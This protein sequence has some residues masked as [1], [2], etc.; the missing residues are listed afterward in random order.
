MEA[1]LSRLGATFCGTNDAQSSYSVFI[2]KMKVDGADQARIA[3]DEGE[4]VKAIY[5]MFEDT[6][7]PWKYSERM[8]NAHCQIYLR[9]NITYLGLHK[10]LT[11]DKKQ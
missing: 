7:K 6:F 3:T 8:N 5:H 1:R 10:L 9:M 11:H 4:W 2:V